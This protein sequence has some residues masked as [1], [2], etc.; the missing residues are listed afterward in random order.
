[1]R[2]RLSRF[3]AVVCLPLALAVGGGGA[4]ADEPAP[5]QIYA[6]T[7]RAVALVTAGQ[8]RGSAWLVDRANRL[9]VTNYHVVGNDDAL[10]LVFPAYRD[11]AVIAEADYYLKQAPRVRARVV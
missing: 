7:L 4:A 8:P 10:D 11:G 5:K 2:S 1:M 9:L 6:R 3:F